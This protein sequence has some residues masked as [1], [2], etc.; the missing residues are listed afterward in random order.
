MATLR[1]IPDTFNPPQPPDYLRPPAR[2]INSQDIAWALLA[3][4]FLCPAFDNKQKNA[5]NENESLGGVAKISDKGKNLSKKSKL[6]LIKANIIF[7]KGFRVS[8]WVQNKSLNPAEHVYCLTHWR[9][10]IYWPNL[11]R[12]RK[13]KK[14]S[15]T[16]KVFALFTCFH[17]MKKRCKFFR[18]STFLHDVLNSCSLFFYLVFFFL[19]LLPSR[20][21]HKR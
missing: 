12:K 18:P 13:A 21:L 6:F 15:K 9:P 19:R 3:I 16:W 10:E 11:K 20:F 2:L 5:E 14:I 8:F 4:S 1:A 17:G 7:A